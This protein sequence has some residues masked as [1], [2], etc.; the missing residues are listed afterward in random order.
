MF[1]FHQLTVP[2][3]TDKM[4]DVH[5]DFL[6]RLFSSFSIPYNYNWQKPYS[7]RSVYLSTHLS[8]SV[9]RSNFPHSQWILFRFHASLSLISGMSSKW[10]FMQSSFPDLPREWLP[11]DE[12]L[13][14]GALY[15]FPTVLV[16]LLSTKK[17][18][19]ALQRSVRQSV[20]LTLSR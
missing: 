5:L 15:C 14:Y 18:Y 7:I 9:T 12:I 16:L 20:D 4:A 17:G 3:V 19:I 8:S 1:G 13:F 6:T 10:D 2:E 11:F